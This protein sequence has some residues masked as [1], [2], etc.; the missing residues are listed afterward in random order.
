MT[1]PTKHKLTLNQK[2]HPTKASELRSRS[3]IAKKTLTEYEQGLDDLK[4]NGALRNDTSF[5]EI[6]REKQKLARVI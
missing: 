4:T 6:E 2:I 5:S 3:V 1:N